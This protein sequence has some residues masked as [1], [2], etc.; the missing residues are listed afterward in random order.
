MTL[1]TT[2]KTHSVDKSIR[3]LV[4]HLIVFCNQIG[5]IKPAFLPFSIDS[6]WIYTMI[7]YLDLQITVQV[8]IKLY[9]LLDNADH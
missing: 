7:N 8:S 3:N 2:I 9:N 4:K 6:T 5:H 1:K